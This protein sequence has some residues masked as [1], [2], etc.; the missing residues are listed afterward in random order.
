MTSAFRGIPSVDQVLSDPVIADLI[1]KY[2]RALTVQTVRITLE[3]LRQATHAGQKVD[4]TMEDIQG[5]VKQSL[6]E[7]VKLG[8][9]PVINAS[10]VLIHTNLGRAP[11]SLEAITAML[12]IAGSYNTLEFDLTTGKR[13][14]R[15]DSIEQKLIALTGAE[16]AFVVNNNASAV[17]L[18]LAA[19]ARRKRVVISR[20]QL[21]E[22]G[23]GFRIPEVL[24][25][26]GAKLYEIGTTNRVHLQDYEDALNDPAALVLRVHHS[27]YKIIGFT[28]EPSLVDLV[29]VAA[30]GGHLVI[31]DL[32]SGAVLPTES[33]ASA[34]EPMVQESIQAGVDVVCFSGDKL[35][36]GPQAGILVGKKAALLKIKKH[37]FARAVR[38]DKLCLAA[39]DATVNHYLKEEAL[40]KIPLWQMMSLSQT[41]CETRARNWH[42]SLGVGEV[43][44]GQST[45]GGGSMPE[46]TIPSKLLSI[47]VARINAFMTHL[48]ALEYP[49]IA[50]VMQDRVVF[51]PRTVLPEQE[52]IFVSELMSLLDQFK[53]R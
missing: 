3:A 50:R 39:L 28:T 34:H 51:D 52:K 5:S 45:I 6:Q 42:T 44:D 53:L 7:Q 12:S 20:T 13:G 36:G 38:A 4:A 1:S 15:A 9:R 43:V 46:E 25:Q 10:G 18:V 41:D 33:Y 26:S 32:G 47:P 19:L 49:I 21:V 31:D 2:G 30:K 40:V 22:I 27:N 16:D 29:K 35:F 14:K 24:E 8:I 23:G 48:R 37:P 11:L 17:M